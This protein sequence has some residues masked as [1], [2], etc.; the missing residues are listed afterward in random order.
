MTDRIPA[1]KAILDTH[2]QVRAKIK[3]ANVAVH[4]ALVAMVNYQDPVDAGRVRRRRRYAA[5]AGQRQQG[6]AAHT[7]HDRRADLFA[8]HRQPGIQSVA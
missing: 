8:S 3:A 4:E 6:E 1:S 7:V 2:T 5:D